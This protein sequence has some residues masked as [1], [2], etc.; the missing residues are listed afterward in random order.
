MHTAKASPSRRSITS[1]V[2]SD[3]EVVK[4]WPECRARVSYPRHLKKSQC[5]LLKTF[6]TALPLTFV[7][8]PNSPSVEISRHA[9]SVRY[10]DPMVMKIY[11]SH[12]DLQQTRP[13]WC[14]WVHFRLNQSRCLR[15]WWGPKCPSE[16]SQRRFYL[17]GNNQHQV[18]LKRD[19]IPS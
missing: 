6:N 15:R 17:L 13:E 16:Y 7:L 5:L 3:G 2:Q 1:D 9:V 4:W 14:S 8:P 12:R 19:V 11:F 18:N 10:I